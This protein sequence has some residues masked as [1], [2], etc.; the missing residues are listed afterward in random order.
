MSGRRGRPPLCSERLLPLTTK[1]P[2]SVHDAIVR[3]SLRTD[4]STHDV[5]REAASNLV[6]KNR[7]D[8]EKPLA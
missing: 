6:A 5:M 8:A 1:L 4:R 7:H 2:A 3:I